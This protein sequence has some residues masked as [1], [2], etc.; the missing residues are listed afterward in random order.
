M[1]DYLFEHWNGLE[2]SLARAQTVYLFCDF[3]GTLAR[4]ARRP[5]SAHL[6][7]KHH[8][9]LESLASNKKFRI[10][11]ISGRSILQLKRL[12]SVDGV[13]YAGNHGFEISGPK[14]SYINPSAVRRVKLLK[15]AA[16]ELQSALRS[17]SGV[18]VED[19]GLTVS[20]HYR[21]SKPSN[22]KTVVKLVESVASKHR[23]LTLTSGKMIVELRP[24]VKWHKGMA[25]LKLLGALGRRGNVIFIGDDTTDE[26]AFQSLK[27]NIT[28]RVMHK[29]VKTSAKYYL[30]SV[31]EVWRFI[32]LLFNATSR[33][34]S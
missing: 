2:K 17:I 33:T 22:R 14:I 8:K 25:A 4:I 32:G 18:I 7:K 11:I 26:D 19:K 27:G 16:R 13:Y 21:M 31:S 30:R 1:A 34:I 28:V 5:E 12:V 23:G 15:A 20:V 29:R 3:D 6:E 9:L 10:A 24:R